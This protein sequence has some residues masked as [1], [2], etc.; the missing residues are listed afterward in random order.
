MSVFHRTYFLF[1]WCTLGFGDWWLSHRL[2][3]IV[4]GKTGKTTSLKSGTAAA[5]VL[6]VGYRWR[7]LWWSRI[8]IRYRITTKS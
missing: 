6:S 7:R 4:I 2:R 8:R 5:A 1:S 3:H